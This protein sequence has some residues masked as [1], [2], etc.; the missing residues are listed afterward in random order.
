M[1]HLANR[2]FYDGILAGVQKPSRYIDRELNLSSDG[3]RDGWYNV[4]L[5]F[6][7]LYEIGMS[8]QGIR[9]LY[10]VLSAVEGVG[11]EFAFP[12]WPDCEK[13]MRASGETLR[14]Y[15][16]GTPASRF[17]LIGFSLTYELHY[18]NLLLSLDLS[19][20]TL[21]A[22]S[23]KE[24]DP[25]V[26][27]GGPCCTN[28]LPFVDA[29]DAVFL[30]DGEDSIMEAVEKLRELKGA[31]A[32]RGRMVEGLAG[33]EGVYVE[34]ITREAKAR[35]HLFRRGDLPR[36][37]VVPSAEIV[38]DRLSVEIM[39]GCT[40]GCRFCH[41]GIFYR[42]RRERQVDEI[43]EAVC[44]GLD[45][46]G[47]EE[48]SLLS[49]SSSDYSR[50]GE[51][52]ERLIP[53]LGARKVSLALPSLRPETV[54]RRLVEA[55]AL[56]R[57][58][59][60]TLAPEAGTERLR[61]VINKGMR[62]EEIIEG[63]RRI[64]DRGWQNLKLYFMVGLPTERE[65]DLIGIAELVRKIL[66]LHAG[67]GRFRLAVSVSP[68][69]PKPHTPFQWERQCSMEELLEKRRF[70]LDRIRGRNVRLSFRDPE[71]SILEGILARG[72][73]AMWP[74]LLRAYRSG[75]RF[76]GWRECSRFDIWREVLG[77]RGL[78][79]EALTAERSM[80]DPLPWR[81]FG[82]RVETG[83]LERE[84]ARAYSGE[85]TPDCRDGN[86]SGCGACRDVP[87]GGDEPRTPAAFLRSRPTGEAARPR[88]GAEG[89]GCYRY[90]C[91]YEKLGRA[92]YLSHIE[93]L[94]I[95]QR[96]L[97]RSGLPLRFTGGFHPRPR[98][99]SG[100]ALAVG[101]EG[102][103]EF[104]DMELTSQADVES[105]LFNGALPEGMSVIGCRGPF[106]RKEGKLPVEVRFRYLLR[107]DSL[108][109]MLKTLRRGDRRLSEELQL[110]Y[111]LVTDLDPAIW[112][113]EL[114]KPGGGGITAWAEKELNEHLKQVFPVRDGEG[115]EKVHG[116]RILD[117]A[118]GDTALTLTFE[119]SV[120]GGIRPRDL[121]GVVLPKPLARL[122]LV[123][124]TEILYRQ[125]NEY[126]DPLGLVAR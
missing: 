51:L 25:L 92:R 68:F 76:D 32:G 21:E 97:R 87:E 102:L 126:L 38:H 11:V 31:G 55:A 12:P 48:V 10:K 15:R 49:L 44:E 64:I 43:V 110:W 42:P 20:L 101:T 123:R 96:A 80:G 106:T 66:E 103:S 63:C 52:L 6:P 112:P 81:R 113:A 105:G 104:F 57:R 14:S 22:A 89:G 115:G 73:R 77:E 30:G 88:T 116:D 122:V 58:S 5:V 56:I 35:V 59:G 100:P 7:D 121:L 69:V 3:F 119:Q 45:A 39:R 2:F 83:F 108:E 91:A 54:S 72:D 23:R 120:K 124:R 9:F 46:S 84:R 41:A 95:L 111:L 85:L 1:V 67:R 36:N 61:S 117:R 28:P 90:R 70:L 82:T 34:G 4:L 74:A 109:R 37:P 27:A 40:R 19:G 62:D 94:N 78:A 50:S 33:I 107:F 125:E 29:V 79:I 114:L 47:W 86:C 99:S 98:I 26:I 18:T 8:H 75:C 53:E 60:F 16:T 17:D 65:E 24:K 13:L 93:T 118:D 71:L